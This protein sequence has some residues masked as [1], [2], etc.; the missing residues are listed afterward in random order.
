MRRRFQAGDIVRTK[1]LRYLL[2][3]D[4]REGC[5]WVH[6]FGEGNPTITLSRC[7]LVKESTPEERRRMLG[8]QANVTRECHARRI[9]KKQLASE[10][11]AC[12][13]Q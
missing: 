8:W 11:E 10:V 5:G 6:A 4:E 12:S 13:A 7:V 9:A 2:A 3:T 1:R